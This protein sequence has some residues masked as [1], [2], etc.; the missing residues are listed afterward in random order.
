MNQNEFLEYEMTCI[1][2]AAGKPDAAVRPM[3]QPRGLR[4]RM[5]L[6]EDGSE[7]VLVKCLD[8][9]YR[10]PSN[11]YLTLEHEAH[12]CRLFAPLKD[13]LLAVPEVK[14]YRAF[15]GSGGETLQVLGQTNVEALGTTL[16]PRDIYLDPTVPLT[17]KEA[18]AKLCGRGL[19]R[20]VSGDLQSTLD[21]AAALARVGEQTSR[22]V[23]HPERD[24]LLELV[25]NHE[26]LPWAYQNK[27][28]GE[29][30][31][32][33]PR[34]IEL[35][36]RDAM[37][38]TGAVLEAIRR[39]LTDVRFV[40][41]L[42]PGQSADRVILS[43]R[44]RHDNNTLLVFEN[45]R[46][47]HVYEVDL[48]FWG[49]ETMGRLV[50]RYVAQQ[51]AAG[52]G[53]VTCR[54]PEEAAPVDESLSA[55]MPCVMGAFLYHFIRADGERGPEMTLRAVSVGLASLHAAIFSLYVAAL[56]PPGAATFVQDAATLLSSPDETIG[57]ASNYAEGRPPEEAEPALEA[58]GEAWIALRPLWELTGELLEL[59]AEGGVSGG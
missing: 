54:R 51:S 53:K 46:L 4:S 57:M 1:R 42:S 29:M 19:A 45:G 8:A 47:R 43:P 23:E 56:F 17:Q 38:E 28:V 7:S 11:L 50:G 3:E 30:N 27:F 13:G 24:R 33:V 52:R 6:L 10:N 40:E 21:R 35:A 14:F 37:P 20:L 48:E 32:L 59:P 39:L 26:A 9:G 31:V 55:Q 34:W 44:D 41:A 5:Y 2:R 16:S 58:I 25:E 15:E 22:I 49:L 12:G 36:G 18:V